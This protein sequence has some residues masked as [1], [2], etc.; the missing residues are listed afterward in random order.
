MNDRLSSGLNAHLKSSPKALLVRST[1]IR[2]H[3]HFGHLPLR[4]NRARTDLPKR[5]ETGSQLTSLPFDSVAKYLLNLAKSMLSLD[6]D[7]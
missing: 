3:V 5:S 4:W 1:L 2:I 6:S 7:I